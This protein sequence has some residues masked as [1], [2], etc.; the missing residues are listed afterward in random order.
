MQ[1]VLLSRKRIWSFCRRFV[2]VWILGTVDVTSGDR[3][4]G[5]AC[6]SI[7][8]MSL[9]GRMVVLQTKYMYELKR[10]VR[11]S[12]PPCHP[13]QR[14]QWNQTAR[15]KVE[16][17]KMT[18][19]L[20]PSRTCATID[21]QPETKRPIY[22]QLT[23][24]HNIIRSVPR[25]TPRGYDRSL[26]WLLPRLTSPS[27]HCDEFRSTGIHWRITVTPELTAG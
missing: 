26:A 2:G 10:R 22:V 8:T 27:R 6:K 4:F 23:I 12:L 19:S 14:L 15:R 1:S 3:E 11:V 9:V 17:L 20:F 7:R 25:A 5:C 16:M 21:S 13:V 24:D 18:G